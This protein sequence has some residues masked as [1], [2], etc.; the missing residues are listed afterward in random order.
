MH[1]ASA[2][3]ESPL[4][5]RSHIIAQF[6][7]LCNSPNNNLR[8]YIQKQGICFQDRGRLLSVVRY[9]LEQYSRLASCI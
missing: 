3:L 6:F 7:P 4:D 8:S 1:T 5:S 2:T 9:N